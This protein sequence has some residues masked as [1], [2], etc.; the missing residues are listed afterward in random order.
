MNSRFL[1][2]RRKE[3]INVSNGMRIGYVDD[4]LFDIKT[5]EISAILVYG[6]FRLFGLLGRE[7]DMVIDWKD[8]ELVGEDTILVKADGDF[9]SHREK[10]SA[11]GKKSFFEK[12]FF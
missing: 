4:F 6:R 2:F 12:L 1:E 11:S 8:I 5:A 7:D 9:R 10:K 3:I